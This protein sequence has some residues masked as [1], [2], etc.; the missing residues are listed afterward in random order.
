MK[1]SDRERETEI[2][3]ASVPLSHGKTQRGAYIQQQE[4]CRGQPSSTARGV[5]L[6]ALGEPLGSQID[7]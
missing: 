5:L 3:R 1:S 6:E 7:G 4:L 2:E